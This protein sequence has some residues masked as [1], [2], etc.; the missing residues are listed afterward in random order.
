[1][2]SMRG[3]GGYGA[4]GSVRAMGDMGA[5]PDGFMASMGA[6]PMPYMPTIN[7]GFVPSPVHTSEVAKEDKSNVGNV[8]HDGEGDED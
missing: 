5:P 4:M 2:T 7:Y 3:I 1:M 8:K 6:P